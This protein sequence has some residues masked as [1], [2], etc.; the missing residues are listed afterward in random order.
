MDIWAVVIFGALAVL[1]FLLWRRE[2][3]WR[4]RYML[5]ARRSQREAEVRLQHYIT[6]EEKKKWISDVTSDLLLVIDDECRLQYANLAAQA[7]FG[8]PA[9]DRSLIA[10]TGNLELETLVFEIL[11][12]DEK[13]KVE[14]LIR[15]NDM[16]FLAHALALPEGVGIALTDVAE[17]QRLSRARQDMITNLSHELRTPLTSLKLLA[18]TL[19][20]TAGK[21]PKV[22]HDLLLKLVDEVDQLDQMSEELLELSAIESGKQPMRLMPVAMR[23]IV[24]GPLERLRDQAD[25][26]SVSIQMNVDDELQILADPEQAT[27]VVLNVLHNAIKFSPEGGKVIIEAELAEEAGQALLS[28]ADSGPGIPPEE[29]ERV[30][31]RF[32]RSHWVWGTPGTGLGLAIARHIMQAHGGRIWA[33][34]RSMPE[35]GAIFYLAFGLA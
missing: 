3:G 2:V 32:Y 24:E 30:F 33:E 14:R 26:R 19:L 8:E 15:V 17:L 18:E 12:Q 13:E 1:F 10:Y 29:L 20:G 4:M 6:H 27:R 28:I 23:K 5:Q 25:R 21:D 7:M 34:N 22:G 11:R 35:R 9:E 16:P 31:E